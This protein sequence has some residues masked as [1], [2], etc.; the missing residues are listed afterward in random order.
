MRRFTTLLFALVSLASP[1]AAQSHPDFS[2]K[3]KLDP[4]TAQGPM[5]PQSMT[6]A[7]TQDA[8]TV[9]MESA[10]TTQM[11]DQKVNTVINL[12]GSQ[13]KNTTNTPA[14]DIEMT[15]TAA[16]DSTALVVTTGMQFQ[17]QPVQQT[18]RWSL[19][20]TGKTLRL[21]RIVAVA[22]QS[23]DVKLTFTKQ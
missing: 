2:G 10:A 20:S 22:G 7:I 21:D 3:W 15:S 12:D 9:K 17:G 4:A 23:F 1:L 18:D 11:G 19:D 5:A 16:W 8:K 6:V 14:G 13:S